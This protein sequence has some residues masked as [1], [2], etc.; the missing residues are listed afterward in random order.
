MA[1]D[2]TIIALDVSKRQTGICE[3]RPGQSPRFTSIAFGRKDDGFFDA[4]A[5]AIG[6][7]AERLFVEEDLRDV[8]MV[9][10][11][12][13]E[14]DSTGGSNIQAILANYGLCKAIGGFAQRRGVMVLTAKVQTVRKHF[15]G[16]GGGFPGQK[17]QAKKEVRRV[18]QAL[19]WN[20]PNLDTSDAGA[21]WHWAAHKWNPEAVP[22]IDPEL[23][24]RRAAA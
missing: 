18:C 16:Y 13:L 23:F 7:I 19:G 15:I 10:E 24:Y 20:P 3:G 8:R 6:W 5:R 11:A 1:F 21:L 22:A 4:E 2:G 14:R 12:P 9:I 17:D